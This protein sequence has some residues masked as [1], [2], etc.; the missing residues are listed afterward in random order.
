MKKF[1]ILFLFFLTP[2]LLFNQFAIAQSNQLINPKQTYTY[3]IMEKDIKK[4]SEK[5]PDI[6]SYKIIG[7]SEY[8]R[9]IYAIK[10][11]KGEANVFINGSHHA[12]EWITTILNMYMIEQYASYYNNNI[13]IGEYNVKE[14]LNNTSIW[15]VPMVNPDGV[16]L[17]Q[18]GVK[19]FPEPIH[20]KLIKMNGGNKNF[21]RWKANA[22]GVDL[23]RQY[24]ANWENIR[25]NPGY[26]KWSH[27]KG[28]APV[29]TTETKTIVKFTYEI[30]PEIAVSYH[31]TGEI[32]YWN[33]KQDK[34]REQRDYKIAKK[35]S[36]YTG[37]SLVKPEA[38]PSGGGFTDWFIKEFKRP[39]FTPELAPYMKDTH[40]PVSYFDAIW[41]ENKLIGLYVAKEGYKLYLERNPSIK[42]FKTNPLKNWK[43]TNE[44]RDFLPYDTLNL[45]SN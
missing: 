1:I 37:Y 35:I 41:K 45:I 31:S 22:N 6:I 10:L 12:R 39:A 25:S 40:V 3:E 30:N 9:N 38:N 16:T 13:S 11:G 33:F 20:D 5:Y 8:G 28:E 4:L 36:D 29:A 34:I 23:N 17:Q 18:F 43:S 15:F 24:D 21:T 27:Y 14:I 42:F 32:I 2:L 26:P 19:Y 44:Y 7:K